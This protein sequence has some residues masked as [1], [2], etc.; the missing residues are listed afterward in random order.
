MAVFF[1]ATIFLGSFL[2]FQVELIIAKI[3]LPWFGGVASVWTACMLFFQVMLFLG[4]LY[5]HGMARYLRPKSQFV[6]HFALLCAAALLLPILPDA[7]WK[8]D[9]TEPPLVLILTLLASVVGLPFLLLSSTSPLLS[10]WFAKAFPGKSPYWLYAMS[11]LGSMLGLLSYP[12]L[13]EPNLTIKGQAYGWS[14]AFL[15]F[16]A[17]CVFASVKGTVSAPKAPEAE[18]SPDGRGAENPSASPGLRDRF[19]WIALPACGS[20]LLLGVT[21]HLAQNVVSLPFLWVLPLS[22]YLLSFVLAFWSPPVY[23]RSVFLPLLAASLV[24]MAVLCVKPVDGIPLRILIPVFLIGMFA[25]CMVLHGELARMAPHP[26]YLTPYYLALSAGGALGGIFVGIVAPQIFRST[27]ELPLGIAACAILALAALTRDPDG[28]G[29]RALLRKAPAA[30]AAILSI[31]GAAY[32]LSPAFKPPKEQRVAARNF[33]GV[34]RVADRGAPGVRSWRRIIYNGSINHGI[35]FLSPERRGEAVSFFHPDS[36][37]GLAVRSRAGPGAIRVGVIGLGAGILAAYGRPGDVYRFYEINPLVVK[38][39][40]TEFSYLR[41]SRA[42]VEV[43]LGDARLSME[44]EPR[45]GYDVLVVDAFSGD[46]PPV[47]LLTRE[48]LRLYLRHLNGNGILA[49]NITNWYINLESVLGRLAEEMGLESIVINT[50]YNRDTGAEYARWVL[51]SAEPE[52]FGKEPIAGAGNPL[53]R[54]AGM[55]LWTDDYSSLVPV[56]HFR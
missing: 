20:V 49:L 23:P 14:G 47:H 34:L 32:L 37:V 50:G 54:R 17:M 6:V 26:R 11:N 36:G 5:A 24:G 27:H 48:A 45:Q 21:N 30:L 44:R 55:P 1:A 4:Y 2:L 51:L 10:S 46:T 35:Q 56:L 15:A 13:V 3:I 29:G 31:V 9:G 19:F 39:A 52:N 25:G 16:S 41:D 22:L 40:E 7:S 43:S 8:P 18:P 38:V 42:R 12:T 33:Y 28:S 53:P